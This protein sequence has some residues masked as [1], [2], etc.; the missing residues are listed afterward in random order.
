MSPNIFDILIYACIALQIFFMTIGIVA[1]YADSGNRNTGLIPMLIGTAFAFT[2]IGMAFYMS[3]YATNA[4][5]NLIVQDTQIETIN[6]ANLSYEDGRLNGVIDDKGQYHRI[7]ES[8][9]DYDKDTCTIRAANVSISNNNDKPSYNIIT[10][11]GKARFGIIAGD[12]TRITYNIE[13]P[14]KLYYDY[15]YSTK[16]DG[17]KTVENASK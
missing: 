10:E 13:L 3:I 12:V 15:K 7:Y 4:K 1:K 17:I 11:K 16:L 9:Q 6:I 5:H 8:D 2:A 14:E